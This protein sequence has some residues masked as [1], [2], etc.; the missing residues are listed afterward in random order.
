[1]ARVPTDDGDGEAVVVQLLG[2]V[3]ADA[4]RAAP[5][6]AFWPMSDPS[7]RG[8]RAR[9]LAATSAA[10]RHSTSGLDRLPAGLAAAAVSASIRC[11]PR[12]GARRGAR[13]S[14]ARRRG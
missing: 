1:V 4:P 12:C 8:G 3:E 6:D 13:R 14:A 5:D 9:T 11:P 10:G 7:V 2:H